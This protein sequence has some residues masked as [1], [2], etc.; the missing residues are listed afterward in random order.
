MESEL[1]RRPFPRHC[2]AAGCFSSLP[3]PANEEAGAGRTEGSLPRAAEVGLSRE[4]A[5]CLLS[6]PPRPGEG[7][8]L[9]QPWPLTASPSGGLVP[10]PGKEA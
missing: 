5:A 3:T 6:Q 8:H 1:G 2:T 4:G 7:V 10:A 9:P